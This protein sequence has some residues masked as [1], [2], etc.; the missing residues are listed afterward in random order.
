MA[1]DPT[2][3]SGIKVCWPKG[4]F[5]PGL[6]QDDQPAPASGTRLGQSHSVAAPTLSTVGALRQRRSGGRWL[7]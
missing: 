5:C 6:S 7:Y 3:S 4:L 2:E 1:A